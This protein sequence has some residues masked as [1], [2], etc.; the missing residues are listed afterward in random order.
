MKAVAALILMTT[1][2]CAAGCKKEPSSG[3]FYGHD[4]VDLGLPSGTLW[5][6]CNVGANA[7]EE[8]GDYFAWGE[9][10]PKTTY[11]WSTYKYC[12]GGDGW[13]TL[14]KYSNIFGYGYNGFTDDLTVLQPSDDVVTANL[15]GGWRMPTREDW[16]ELYLNTTNKWTKRNG[17]NGR[18]F[19]ASNGNSF[20][21]PAAGYSWDGEFYDVG[22]RGLYWSSSLH[23]DDPYDAWDFNFGSSGYGMGYHYR[24]NGRSVRPVLSAL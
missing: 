1:V 18:L 6:T 17:V 3:S 10:E 9:I 2:V 23:M 24:S 20:F 14:T 7:P 19:T 13:N 15:G 8:Y 16:A 4:Y 21:L 11:N 22:S 5:A 12:N